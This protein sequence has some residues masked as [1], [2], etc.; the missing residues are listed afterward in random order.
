MFTQRALSI[1]VVEDHGHSCWL[2]K[3][4]QPTL[5][6]DLQLLFSP[7][8]IPVATGRDVSLDED[9]SQVRM[10]Q[11]PHVLASLNNAVCGLIAQAGIT[12]LAALQR[13]MVSQLDRILF[14]V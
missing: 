6:D 10:G 7:Q 8:L 12:K 9:A 4:N 1:Q 5:R 14:R 11:A 2:V 13:A 3:A